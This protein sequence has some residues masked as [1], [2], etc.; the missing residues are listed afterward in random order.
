MTVNIST[1]K[2]LLVITLSI[3]YL[4]WNTGIHSDD[5]LF[6]IFISKSNISFIDILFSYFNYPGIPIL[7]PIG[8][9]FSHFFY[10]LFGN[11]FLLYDVIKILV[12]LFS[13]YVVYLFFREFISKSKALLISIFFV[14][15]ITHDSVN[16]W[17]ATQFYL[18]TL[19]FL[20]ISYK[21][22]CN[23]FY[24]A[25]FITG[26]LGAFMGY[27]SPPYAFGLSLIFLLRKQFKQ[28]FIFIIP[29][30]FYIIYYF[31]AT[32]FYLSEGSFLNKIDS[33][34]TILIIIKQYLLQI[35]TFLDAFFGVSFWLKL[36][37]SFTQLTWI[38]V[39]VG[40]VLTFIFYRTYQVRKYL[41]FNQ[42]QKILLIALFGVLLSA[43]GIYSLTGSNPQI[44]FNLGNRVTLN[45]SLLIAFLIVFFLFNNKKIATIVF[46]LFIFSV[47]GISDHWKSWHQTKLKVMHNMVNNSDIKNF[48]TK[49][50]LFIIGNN[51]SKFSFVS[52]IEAEPRGWLYLVTGKK[53]KV[54]KL[55]PSQ[56][57][58]QDNYLINK[59]TGKKELIIN[60]IAV[61]NTMTNQLFIIPKQQIV[62]YLNEQPKDIRHWLLLFDRDSFLMQIVLKLIPRLEYVLE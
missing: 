12:A 62:Q 36:G 13:L 54:R 33:N 47:L 60:S 11:N 20:I 44:T 48:N 16:Y 45:G 49:K 14:F 59:K 42:N 41:A 4:Y 55:L 34:I 21:C 15:F 6:L 57:Y 5:L 2:I 40:A 53:Y 50:K 51:Y 38:S 25:G 28:F 7:A 10:S 18:L 61:Y 43:F 19:A 8:N 27:T 26:F 46:A 32:K 52:H 58:Y 35:G 30:V 22:I 31:W 23:K 24:K 17:F 3:I 9:Y 56:F 29:E 39:V 1:K 37:L